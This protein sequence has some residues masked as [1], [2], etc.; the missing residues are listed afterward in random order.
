MRISTRFHSCFSSW[1]WE[2]KTRN[3]NVFN[4]PCEKR[5]IDKAACDLSFSKKKHFSLVKIFKFITEPGHAVIRCQTFF[6]FTLNKKV[7]ECLY[8]NFIEKKQHDSYLCP[9]TLFFSH[10]LLSFNKPLNQHIFL[11]IYHIFTHFS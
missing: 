2:L 10:R 6:H 4:N 7:H 8:L 5:K 11:I 9:L 3:G 1:T